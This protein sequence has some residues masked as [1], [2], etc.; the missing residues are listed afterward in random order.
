MRA[1]IGPDFFIYFYKSIVGLI[2]LICFASFPSQST[3]M[4]LVALYTF[5]SHNSL[6]AILY[7][8]KTPWN[9][10]SL[11][12]LCH[13]TPTVQAGQ[14]QP[15]TQSFLPHFK[16]HQP[17][18]LCTYSQTPLNIISVHPDGHT[19]LNIISVHT[20]CTNATDT[21]HKHKRKSEMSASIFRWL[22]HF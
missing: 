14:W 10:L 22:E 6:P 17:P 20:L 12:F 2:W 11:T 21:R 1:K 7:F 15:S 9:N 5:C 8:T 4:P 3:V 13:H 18:L 16:N 19:P